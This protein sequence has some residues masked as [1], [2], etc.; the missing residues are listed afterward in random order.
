MN[1]NLPINILI[2][3]KLKKKK[4]EDFKN[5]KKIYILQKETTNQYFSMIK[6]I[7]KLI[8]ENMMKAKFS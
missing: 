5:K 6:V 3:I 1:W 7:S 8:G 2:I 4:K